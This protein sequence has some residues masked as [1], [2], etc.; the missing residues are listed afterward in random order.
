[1]IDKD[2]QFTYSSVVSVNGKKVSVLNISP[3]PAHDLLKIQHTAA[4]AGSEIKILSTD[5]RS[6]RSLSVA[7]GKTSTVLN[8][9]ALAK[10]VYLLQYSNGAD[11]VTSQ[12]IK[13]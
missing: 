11:K 3:N 1:M 2:R 5:G 10:G 12:F 4:I 8:V 9:N 7:P 13:Q 6:L